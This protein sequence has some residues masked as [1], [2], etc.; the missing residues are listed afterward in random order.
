LKERNTLSF[1][2]LRTEAS[3]TLTQNQF[4]VTENALKFTYGRPN[5]EF[6]HFPGG[7]ATGLSS[8]GWRGE[9]KWKEG[10]LIKWMRRTGRGD[11]ME[12]KRDTIEA[13]ERG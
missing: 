10:T 12:E 9:R 6:I 7:P 13:M 11:A 8:R 5:V 4:S 1:L 2:W 3:I